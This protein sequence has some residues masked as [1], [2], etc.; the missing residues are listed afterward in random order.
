MALKVR[1][2]RVVFTNWAYLRTS[3]AANVG[4]IFG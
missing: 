3:H 4:L 1:D 2:D